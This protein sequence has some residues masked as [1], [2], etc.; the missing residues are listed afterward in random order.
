MCFAKCRVQMTCIKLSLGV[1]HILKNISSFFPLIFLWFKGNQQTSLLLFI[2]KVQ[3]MEFLEVFLFFFSPFSPSLSLW[4]FP[5]TFLPLSFSPCLPCSVFYFDNVKALAV[6]KVT[7]NTLSHVELGEFQSPELG[8]V[9][10]QIKMKSMHILNSSWCCYQVC[11]VIIIITTNTFEMTSLSWC[12]HGTQKFAV[13]LSLVI[14]HRGGVGGEGVC[15]WER[16]GG[17]GCEGKQAD[18]LT[19][20]LTERERGRGERD[21]MKQWVGIRD[22]LN[23][24]IK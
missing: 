8:T 12:I 20:T 7:G 13:W 19:Q 23:F 4:F 9:H 11:L 24:V 1:S 17:G 14:F 3:C 22:F 6:L 5:A 16:K 2:M 21:R 18:G 10:Y 15:V